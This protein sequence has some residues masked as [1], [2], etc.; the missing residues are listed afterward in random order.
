MLITQSYL[1]TSRGSYRCLFF[2][3]LEDYIEAQIRFVR[4]LDPYLERF[5]RNL[6][7]SAALV[8]P[9]AGDI[10]TTRQHVLSKNWSRDQ[11]DE[12]AK[13]PSLLMIN[14]DFDTFDPLLH[15]WIQVHFGERLYDAGP[16]VREFGQMLD[17]LAK[18]VRDS[19]NDIFETAH[20]LLYEVRL[21]DAAKV[22]EAKPGIFGF[23][24]DLVRGADVL[25]NLYHRLAGHG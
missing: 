14:N 2:L 19:E 23:S 25:R 11:L 21:S 17:R 13:T 18:A 10:E 22:F 7:D 16:G 1:G 3:L 4:D 5:A 12:I 9:F 8:R 15:P 24:I 20:N 6:G